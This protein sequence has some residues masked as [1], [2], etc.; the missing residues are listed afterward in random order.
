[1]HLSPH[2]VYYC[3]AKRPE[4]PDQTGTRVEVKILETDT[5]TLHNGAS[6]PNIRLWVLGGYAAPSTAI[7]REP[8]GVLRSFGPGR[9]Y[10]QWLPRSCPNQAPFRCVARIGNRATCVSFGAPFR[11]QVQNDK[12][13]LQYVQVQGFWESQCTVHAQ[14]SSVQE[15]GVRGS[16]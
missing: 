3:R 2:L 9:P 6:R 13:D 11:L 4:S 5:K 1:M 14:Q 8:A 10:L 16:S 12:I 7:L 15:A